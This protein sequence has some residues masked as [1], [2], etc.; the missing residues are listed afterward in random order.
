ML[1]EK[2]VGAILHYE[3]QVN[4]R[5]ERMLKQLNSK[6]K[7][8][9]LKLQFKE[10]HFPHCFEKSIFRAKL[11]RESL[12]KFKLEWIGLKFNPPLLPPIAASVG[13][14]EKEEKNKC[15]DKK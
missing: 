8:P 11:Y 10:L 4:E 14:N 6:R 5:K 7:D 2:K 15:L 12:E 13:L 3:S 1:E 9:P